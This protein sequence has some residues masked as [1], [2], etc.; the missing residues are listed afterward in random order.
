MT[1]PPLGTSVT[2]AGILLRR[3]A[4]WCGIKEPKAGQALWG[5]ATRE[6]L[7]VFHSRT[8][9]SSGAGGED[10]G[11]GKLLAELVVS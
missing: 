7:G 8:E 10:R 4:L 5:G 3:K 2:P 6:T 1:S 9:I 11:W